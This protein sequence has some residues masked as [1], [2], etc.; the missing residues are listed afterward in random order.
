[1]IDSIE[2][3]KPTDTYFIKVDLDAP[4]VQVT[5]S[6]IKLYYP[7]LEGN[8]YQNKPMDGELITAPKGSKIPLNS[9]VYMNYLASE[10]LVK[11]GDDDYYVIKDDLIVAYDAGEGRKAYK[12]ILVS[13]RVEEDDSKLIL[14]TSEDELISAV[15]NGSEGLRKSPITFGEV[16]DADKEWMQESYGFTLEE[17]DV[18][19][20]ESALD[21]EYVV[22]RKTNYYIKWGD[23]IIRKDGE[24]V[25]DYNEIIPI[26]KQITKFGLVSPNTERFTPVVDGKFKGKKVLPDMKRVENGKYI[27]SPYLFGHLE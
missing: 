20:Y 24:I 23:R 22:N 9:T 19:E 11:I 26:P 15:I 16:I 7:D 18:I 1:M 12:S 4:K 6:G 27:K 25:N 5:D 2:N 3:Y 13:P 14:D 8:T 17:G 10:S 21:W